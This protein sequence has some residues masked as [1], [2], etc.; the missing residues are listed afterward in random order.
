LGL[1]EKKNCFKRFPNTGKFFF[2]IYYISFLRQ[3]L[4]L[5]FSLNFSTFIKH[6]LKGPFIPIYLIR[7]TLT[8]YLKDPD[9]LFTTLSAI[10]SRSRLCFF[11]LNK[12]QFVFSISL[13]HICRWTALKKYKYNLRNNINVE[14][15]TLYSKKFKYIVHVVDQKFRLITY[16]L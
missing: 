10:F 11:F 8:F 1:Y 7:V 14:N 12:I 9:A 2:Y 4:T 15:Y 6:T 5:N 13:S 16:W 3:E